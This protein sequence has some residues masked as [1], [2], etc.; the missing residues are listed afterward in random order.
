MTPDPID[1][2]VRLSEA[3]ELA[4]L[5]FEH[6]EGKP[7]SDEMRTRLAGRAALLRMATVRPYF[8]SLSR[9]PVHP[10]SYYLSV[11]GVSGQP[12]LL[13]IALST[14]PTSSIFFKPTLIGRTRRPLGPEMV[15][16][17][18]PFRP[19]DR[20]S[21]SQFAASIDPAFLPRPS[22]A[23]PSIELLAEAPR[24]TFPA[25]FDTFRSILKRTG[26]NLAA[27][28]AP[29]GADYADVYFSALWAAVRSGWRE[30]YSAGAEFTATDER[31]ES[32][33]EATLDTAAFTRFRVD[34]SFFLDPH[35][36]ASESQRFGRS[37]QAAELAYEWIRQTRSA[38]KT[39]RSFD[40]EL[41]L[42]RTPGA[43]TPEELA[44]CLGSLRSEGHAA[45]LVAPQLAGVA[46]IDSYVAA[47][48]AVARDFQCVLSFAANAPLET[49][50]RAARG[51]VSLTVAAGPAD[52]AEALHRAAEALAV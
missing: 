23:R 49:V 21:L 33:K 9:D 12:L 24:A 29:P 25:A 52:A 10:S 34:T 39:G 13:H 17:A 32:V 30:G 36:Q 20:E 15:I 42:R 28:A 47:L 48:A 38:L 31:M 19:E 7:L 2:P 14:A 37:L 27:I 43:T 51:R 1:L 26:Q 16:N 11:D 50:G 46:D 22:G 8:G 44:Y 5:I 45:Q 41:S 4:N 3:S 6:A 18:I 40:F 35:P